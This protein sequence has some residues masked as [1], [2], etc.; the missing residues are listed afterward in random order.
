MSGCDTKDTGLDTHNL[1]L[2]LYT[3]LANEPDSDFGWASGKENARALGYD[4][5]GLNT[6]PECVW[7]SA[8]AVGNPFSLGPIHAGETV[9]DVGCGAGADACVAAL[10]VGKEGNVFG[11]DCTPAMIDKAIQ[12]ARVSGLTNTSFHQ[13]EMTALPLP[14]A[15]AD[16]VISNG[17][18]NLAEDKTAV[19]R[20]VFRVLRPGGRLQIADMVQVSA[21]DKPACCSSKN[22]WADCI[23]GTVKPNEFLSIME[24]TGFLDVQLVNFTSY[25][26][27]ASTAGALIKAVKPH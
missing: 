24:S 12:N 10:L 14:G 16:V 11:I 15:Y 4:S 1:L 25:K 6:L 23:S 27:A 22:S 20:E 9:V 26:T 21:A 5:N 18:V 17:A 13:A 8:A 2:E 19:L 7:E 3:C